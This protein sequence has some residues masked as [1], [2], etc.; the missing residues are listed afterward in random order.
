MAAVLGDLYE[1]GFRSAFVEGGPT[2]ASAFLRAGLADEVLVYQAPVL[3]GGPRLAVQDV[4]VTT[5]EKALRLE[6]RSVHRLGEDV[7]MISRPKGR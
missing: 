3:L 5:L 2:L 1:R 7:L 4:G 6:M